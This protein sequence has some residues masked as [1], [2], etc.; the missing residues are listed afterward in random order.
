MEVSI[1]IILTSAVV[2]ALVTGWFNSRISDKAIQVKQITEERTKWR[3]RIRGFLEDIITASKNSDS[4]ELQG[5][6]LRLSSRLNPLDE[7]DNQILECLK[8]LREKPDDQDV[9][10]EFSARITLLLKHDWDRA[11]WEA[12]AKSERVGN[13]PCRCK[14]AYDESQKNS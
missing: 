8:K 3:E 11:K 12:T 2:A 1:E 5:L 9:L 13:K 7:H 6:R 4:T 10:E 14:Y